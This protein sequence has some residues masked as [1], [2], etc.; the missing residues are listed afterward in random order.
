MKKIVSIVVIFAF[1]LSSLGLWG[2]IG[3]SNE[4]RIPFIDFFDENLIYDGLYVTVKCDE[5]IL[6]VS[7]FGE[8]IVKEIRRYYDYNC[9]TQTRKYSL[10]LKCYSR[11]ELINAVRQIERIPEVVEVE[12]EYGLEYFRMPNDKF[13]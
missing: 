11:L 1:I 4:K 13:R 7:F 12:L 10:T 2:C 6:P 5:D 3:T 8:D 9:T